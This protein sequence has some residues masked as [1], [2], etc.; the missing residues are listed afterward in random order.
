V[1]GDERAVRAAL[2]V[3]RAEH[4]V[5]DDE[6]ALAVEEIGERAAPVRPLEDVLLLDG[7]HRQLAALGGERVALAAQLFLLGE[8][9]RARRGPLTSRYDGRA[10]HG[11]LLGAW[12]RDLIS[13]VEAWWR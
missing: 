4:E 12:S 10:L 13:C 5:V 7:H 9:P 8:E 6:L 11:H 3:I 1:V 2:V